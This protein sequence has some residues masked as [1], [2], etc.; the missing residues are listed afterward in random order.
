MSLYVMSVCMCISV[1]LY[2]SV[3]V[4]VY[5]HVCVCVC[6]RHIPPPFHDSQFLLINLLLFFNYFLNSINKKKLAG[7]YGHL[8][9]LNKTVVY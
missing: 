6:I 5:V 2:A 7:S 1:C 3:S 8:R 9:S 4:R